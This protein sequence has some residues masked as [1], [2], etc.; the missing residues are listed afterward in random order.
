M[1][2]SICRHLISDRYH[3]WPAADFLRVE[4][5]FYERS[6]TRCSAQAGLPEEPSGGSIFNIHGFFGLAALQAD[7]LQGR[8][9][10][11]LPDGEVELP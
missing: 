2:E 5:A 4:K 8:C 1:L 6:L 10:L 7:E 11:L 3:A 9:D